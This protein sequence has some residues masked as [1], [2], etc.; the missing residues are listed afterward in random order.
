MENLH[1]LKEGIEKSAEDSLRIRASKKNV[2][3]DNGNMLYRFKADVDDMDVVVSPSDF[4]KVISAVKKIEKIKLTK[5]GKVEIAGGTAKARIGM[6]PPRMKIAEEDI[7]ESE[8]IAMGVSIYPLLNVQPI[9][10]GK[11]AVNRALN[12]IYLGD[13][14][15]FSTDGGMIIASTCKWCDFEFKIP[16]SYVW[17]ISAAA[18]VSDKI[19]V[20]MIGNHLVLNAKNE[21]NEISILVPK[22]AAKTPPAVDFIRNAPAGGV[23]AKTKDFISAASRV[24]GFTSSNRIGVKT[25]DGHLLISSSGEKD[26]HMSV[27]VDVEGSGQ[28]D[29]YIFSNYAKLI[30]PKTAD[31]VNLIDSEKILY[32]RSESNGE[33]V[34]GVISKLPQE[35]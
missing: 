34:V 22:S 18:I 10:V 7:E 23:S 4:S 8:P 11:A 28:I 27:Q 35:I 16:Y 15:V 17:A 6:M 9:S 33:D 20:G 5:S 31:I 12:A 3:I 24:S 21:D 30:A 1:K 14:Y 26:N 19:N 29:A 25:E 13:G 2:T 32:S